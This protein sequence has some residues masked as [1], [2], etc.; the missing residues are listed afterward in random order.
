MDIDQ[1][2]DIMDRQFDPQRRP[3][4]GDWQ[5]AARVIYDNYAKHSVYTTDGNGPSGRPGRID[6]Q[7][8]YAPFEKSREWLTEQSRGVRLDESWSNIQGPGTPNQ[9]TE[10]GADLV[11]TLEG[12]AS[13]YFISVDP[14][15][16]KAGV[17]RYRQ[18][19][20]KGGETSKGDVPGKIVVRD[21]SYYA[22]LRHQGRVARELAAAPLRAI[23]QQNRT[24]WQGR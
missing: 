6:D 22:N 14:K 5:V 18:P 10:V 16:K 11:Q 2:R 17:Y 12:D 8:R 7:L 15:T 4:Y 21:A 23:N 1:A 20:I 3:R 9:G 13:S 24:F 19:G